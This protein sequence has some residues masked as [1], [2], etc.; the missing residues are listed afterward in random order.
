[1][2]S[3]TNKWLC[4]IS[5]NNMECFNQ[6]FVTLNDIADNLGLSFNIVFDISSKRRTSDKYKDCRFF[7]QISITR[8]P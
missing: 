6:E 1:M 7:P 3:K 5:Q 4:I 8:L 2:R